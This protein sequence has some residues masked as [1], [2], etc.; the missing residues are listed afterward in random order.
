MIVNEILLYVL[1]ILE[2]YGGGQATSA[3]R[4]DV[5]LHS[6]NSITKNDT[7]L[8]RRDL[9]SRGISSRVDRRLQSGGPPSRKRGTNISRG[10]TDDKEKAREHGLI[11][12]EA[13][14]L[15][16]REN[17]KS[18]IAS[19]K[20]IIKKNDE[21]CDV[22]RKL[23]HGE[24]QTDG[25]TPLPRQQPNSSST[26]QDK[27]RLLGE[28]ELVQSVST[29]R[30]DV[31]QSLTNAPTLTAMKSDTA[32]MKQKTMRNLRFNNNNS[33]TRSLHVSPGNKQH[34]G[35]A[36]LTLQQK[37]DVLEELMMNKSAEHQHQQEAEAGP[38]VGAP[39]EQC[40]Q[41]IDKSVC[42]FTCPSKK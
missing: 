37:L 19:R 15:T 14:Y 28:A 32:L 33:S 16:R 4:R 30:L 9:H 41:L 17:I 21:Y 5:D 34:S 42:L 26:I 12:S 6:I 13:N 25:N 18:L 7:T 38:E 36:I 8:I 40:H 27:M 20:E 24:F 29:K 3:S 31:L 10:A 23:L 11:L 22:E 39:R 35:G 1:A 2:A